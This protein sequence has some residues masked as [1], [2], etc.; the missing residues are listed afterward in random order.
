MSSNDRDPHWFNSQHHSFW[1]NPS[2]YDLNSK[3]MLAAVASLSGVILIVFALH[4]YARF[5]LRRRREAFRGLPVVFRH[6]FEMPKRGLN[7][8]VIASLP[9]F[10]VRT[11]DGVAT[12][13]TECAVCL[14][15]LE[16]QDTARELPNCKHI[17]HVDC[18]DTWL[19]TCPTCPVCRTEVE[20]RPRLEP[21]PREGPVG[22]A[23][24]LLE[25]TRL[26]L[27]VEAGTS[28]SSDNKTVA[29]SASRLNSFRKILTRE[30]SSNRINHSCV[31]QDRVADLERH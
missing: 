7:P 20:P 17:F 10:T 23:P 19:T 26:N 6:S 18:V 3:I 21:E 30:R 5:V 13:A 14:S 15:V 12:S 4:L 16:E 29:S 2:S 1:P 31:D 28:S 24:P 25:E 11:T 9:T 22:T 8:A 27:T